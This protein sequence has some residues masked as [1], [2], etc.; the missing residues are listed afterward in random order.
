MEDESTLIVAVSEFEPNTDEFLFFFIR[1]AW[2][3]RGLETFRAPYSRLS[4]IFNELSQ[5]KHLNEHSRL[6]SAFICCF[7]HGII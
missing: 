3:L 4:H 1:S 7:I 2:E 6:I 5:L